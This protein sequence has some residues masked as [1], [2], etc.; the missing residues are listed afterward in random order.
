MFLSN[1]FNVRKV[2][3]RATVVPFEVRPD[4][5]WQVHIKYLYRATADGTILV[6]SSGDCRYPSLQMRIAA[7]VLIVGQVLEHNRVVHF[8]TR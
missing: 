8:R 1:T 6:I 2:L 3:W 5:I 7:D 4:V